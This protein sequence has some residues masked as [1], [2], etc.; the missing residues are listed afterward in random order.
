MDN[1]GISMQQL[2][3]MAMQLNWTHLERWEET[4]K[5]LSI[6]S[7]NRVAREELDTCGEHVMAGYDEIGNWTERMCA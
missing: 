3:H 5:K 2:R 7:A 4:L 6:C 1:L